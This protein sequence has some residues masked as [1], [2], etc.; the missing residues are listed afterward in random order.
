[1]DASIKYT[2]EQLDSM[3]DHLLGTSAVTTL[4]D[5]PIAHKTVIA[6]LSAASALSLS[7]DLEPGLSLE[8]L[9]TP[10]ADIT[11]TLPDGNG[12]TSFKPSLD[13]KS[14]VKVVLVVQCTATQTYYVYM[15]DTPRDSLKSIDV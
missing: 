14:G 4:V 3:M 13:L 10:S 11:L 6:N 9:I 7:S 1:M 12:F 15:K 5:L 2:A 8:V